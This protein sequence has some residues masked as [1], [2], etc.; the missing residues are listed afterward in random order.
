MRKTEGGT[1]PVT[2]GLPSIRRTPGSRTLGIAAVGIALAL[3]GCGLHVSKNGVS[4][5]ILGHSFS[6]SRGS[7]PA[8][9]PSAVPPPDASRVLGGGGAANRWDAAFAVTGT[10]DSGTMAYESKLR[11]A[12]YTISNYQSGSTPVTAGT[13]SGSTATTVTV[14]GAA[15]D[16]S[17]SRWTIQ[18]LSGNTS[19]IQG[20]GLKPGE[21]AIDLVVAPTSST[22]TSAP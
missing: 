16:A 5:N 10:I 6:A 11:A 1:M 12:G 2:A 17:D 7:L 20:T 18:V 9:F 4:G 22:T 19:S 15:F 13:G 21:F 3:A 8:G 14:S